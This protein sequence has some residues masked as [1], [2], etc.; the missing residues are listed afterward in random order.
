MTLGL[1][2][3]KL[4]M[5]QCYD[6]NGALIPVTLVQA[7]PCTI[8]QK[9]V[10]ATDGYNAVQVGFGDV[11][12]KNINKPKMGTLKK[13]LVAN[14]SEGDVPKAKT[15]EEIG[16]RWI[17]EFRVDNPDSYEVGQIINLEIFQEGE[18]VDVV[19]TSK[20]RGFQGVIKRHNQS[21]GPETHG[22]RYHRRPGSMGQ[23]AT[24]ARVFKGKNLP[25]QMGN[26]R[27]T[28]Q[29]LQV[30]KCDLENNIIAIKG[31]VPG[32]PNGM[33]VLR[34]SLKSKKK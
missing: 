5:A 23:S 16:R 25:G 15:L 3:K 24:P 8:L 21:R 6:D 4:G 27:V 14:G 9:K 28:V 19:G 29:G 13:V 22:S 34:K 33:I 11:K 20:G 7:G 2:G 18:K 1:I 32:W 12:E 26:E 30:V 10:V 17:R 31:A